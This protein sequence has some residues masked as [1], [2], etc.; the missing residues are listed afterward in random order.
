MIEMKVALRCDCCGQI[1]ECGKVNPSGKGFFTYVKPCKNGCSR[2]TRAVDSA[3]VPPMPND[4]L[5]EHKRWQD[6]QDIFHR[7]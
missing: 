2:T 1:L 3:D 6:I 7:R 5:D 4:M